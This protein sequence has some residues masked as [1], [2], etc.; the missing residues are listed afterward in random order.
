MGSKSPSTQEKS[1]LR[2][3]GG[4]VDDPRGFLNGLNLLRVGLLSC[5]DLSSAGFLERRGILLGE[6]RLRVD[7]VKVTL[8]A[9]GVPRSV[10]LCALLRVHKLGQTGPCGDHCGGELLS[11]RLQHR[12][13]LA[14]KLLQIFEPGE[15][16]PESRRSSIVESA[17]ASLQ[18]TL[19]GS[20]LLALGNQDSR[21]CLRLF[22]D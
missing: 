13:G 8:G 15:K 7:L 11:V 10:L 4:C 16:R 22:C 17:S 21:L 12:G 3:G 5:S 6:L 9:I 19:G 1:Q 2:L 14:R 18:S 20:M